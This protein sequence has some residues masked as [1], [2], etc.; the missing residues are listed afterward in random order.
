MRTQVLNEVSQMRWPC[1][2]RVNGFVIC[3]G[4]TS[5]YR[6]GFWYIKPNRSNRSF[7]FPALTQAEAFA[8]KYK[9]NH[10]DA[11]WLRLWN[12]FPMW[13]RSNME[14]LCTPISYLE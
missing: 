5:D 6:Y 7:C 2:R 12:S 8:K 11:F 3:F 14:S 10:S 1:N 13:H 9:N 4:E